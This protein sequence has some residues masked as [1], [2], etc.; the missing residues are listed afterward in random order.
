MGDQDLQLR[1]GLGRA[2][3]LPTKKLSP[4]PFL[5]ALPNPAFDW[6]KSIGKNN[7]F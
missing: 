7:S 3:N 5:H 2:L 1:K 6:R 4:S